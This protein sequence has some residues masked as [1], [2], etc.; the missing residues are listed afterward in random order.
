MQVVTVPGLRCTRHSAHLQ[1]LRHCQR[2]GGVGGGLRQAGGGGGVAAQ[3]RHVLALG[4]AQ[5][6]L[7][8]LLLCRQ[9]QRMKVEMGG[10]ESVVGS[11]NAGTPVKQHGE[12]LKCLPRGV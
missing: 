4:T 11:H 2:R 3:Q 6:H 8:L 7:A 5:R 9:G 10:M 1:R 12:D